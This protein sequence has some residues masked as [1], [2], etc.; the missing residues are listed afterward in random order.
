MCMH[1]CACAYMY[2]CYSDVLFTISLLVMCTC[3]SILCVHVHACIF[4]IQMV[5]YHF[6]TSYV[7]MCK[8]FVC[9]CTCMYLC[10][11]DVLFTILLLVMC[12]CVMHVSLLFRC[13]YHFVTSYMYTCKCLVCM[14]VHVFLLFQCFF[15]ISLLVM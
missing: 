8:Y 4:V 5:F 6:V 9:A 13:V 11:S 2:L 10:Y 7:Y 1:V 3:V 12:T 15:T 14:C